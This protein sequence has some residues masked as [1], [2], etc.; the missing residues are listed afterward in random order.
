MIE[1]NNLIDKKELVKINK[2]VENFNQTINNKKHDENMGKDDFLKLLTMQLSHQ[3]PLEPMDNTQ[4]ISQMAQF[5]SLEQMKNIGSEIKMMRE[6]VSQLSGV[7]LIGR[8]AT[9]VDENGEQQKGIIDKMNFRNANQFEIDGKTIGLKN[10][11]SIVMKKSIQNY[12]KQIKQENN[13]VSQ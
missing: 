1:Y 8:E 4:F 9:Y 3:N 7:N 12:E 10:I 13:G 6:E 2:N 11:S 5:T